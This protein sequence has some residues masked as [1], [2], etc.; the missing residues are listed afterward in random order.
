M[1]GGKFVEEV[2]KKTGVLFIPGW[3]FGR[4]GINAIRLSFGPLVEDIDK[5]EE[6]IEKVAIYLKSESDCK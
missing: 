4:T 5:I 3:G 2:L 6:G 1:D